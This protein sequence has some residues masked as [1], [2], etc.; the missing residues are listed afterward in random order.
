[1]IID[2][3]SH[4]GDVLNDGGADLI[5]RENVVMEKMWDPQA[6]NERQ[7]NRSFGLGALAAGQ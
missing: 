7:L 2:V 6:L 5:Y 4:L 3:H 1:M